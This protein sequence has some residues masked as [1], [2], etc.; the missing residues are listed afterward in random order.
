MEMLCVWDSFE[1]LFIMIIP[2]VDLQGFIFE[3]KFVVKK[4]AMLRK[5]N[6]L[7][8]YIFVCSLLCNL[9]TKFDK[10]CVSLID[11]ELS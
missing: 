8:H 9:L 5:R 1:T 6:V 2:F 11:C 3:R 10:S 4:I 7:S